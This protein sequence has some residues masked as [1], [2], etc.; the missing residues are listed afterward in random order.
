MRDGSSWSAG[1]AEMPTDKQMHR[2]LW[3]EDKWTAHLLG[4]CTPISGHYT[5]DN[6]WCDGWSYSRRPSQ[7][8]HTGHKPL[9]A[10]PGAR[11][12]YWSTRLGQMELVTETRPG[13]GQGGLREADVAAC[14]CARR[15]WRTRRTWIDI[16]LQRFESKAPLQ[17]SQRNRKGMRGGGG[18]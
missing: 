5:D 15:L 9:L 12:C 6:R 10:A 13:V 3:W 7:R 14:V 16:E 2:P 1:D 18:R 8:E 11:A 17:R 4:N